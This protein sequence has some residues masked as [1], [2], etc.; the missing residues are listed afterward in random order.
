MGP[1]EH[2][3]GT[4]EHLKEKDDRQKIEELKG[5]LQTVKVQLAIVQE[6]IKVLEQRQG[7]ISELSQS[8]EEI[9]KKFRAHLIRAKGLHPGPYTMF[10]WYRDL[11]NERFEADQEIE[12]IQGDVG[13]KKAQQ[14]FMDE[15]VVAMRIAHKINE[16]IR[17]FES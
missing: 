2:E 17:K 14:E 15:A 12:K 4:V 1:Y 13:L 6:G 10:E 9:L 5:L 11:K 16:L 3:L 8:E 7:K